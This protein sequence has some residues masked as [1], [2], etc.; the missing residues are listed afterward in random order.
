MISWHQWVGLACVTIVGYVCFRLAKGVPLGWIFIGYGL[1]A[2]LLVFGLNVLAGYFWPPECSIRDS[3]FLDSLIGC[4]SIAASA[5]WGLIGG[6]ILS[7]L[8]KKYNG[9]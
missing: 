4:G 8:R 7:I 1:L 9:N 3:I 2:L 5:G 6:G